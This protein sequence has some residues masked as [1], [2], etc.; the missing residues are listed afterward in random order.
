[1]SKPIVIPEGMVPIKQGGRN[2]YDLRAG[3]QEPPA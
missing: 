1:M 2:A 3:K